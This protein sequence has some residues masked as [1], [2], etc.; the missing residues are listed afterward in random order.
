MND[1]KSKNFTKKILTQKL[2]RLL[3]LY[4]LHLIIKKKKE[5]EE[6]ENNRFRFQNWTDERFLYCISIKRHVKKEKKKV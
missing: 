5:D 6:K 1:I 2:V 3:N 4:Q